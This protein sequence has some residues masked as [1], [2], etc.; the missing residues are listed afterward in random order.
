M[1]PAPRSLRVLF[2]VAG[3]F[4]FAASRAGAADEKI[5]F[6]LI[7]QHALVRQRVGLT[8][9]EV[10]YSRP[11]KNKRDIF[12]G[13]VPWEQVWRTGANAPTKIKFS[14]AVQLGGQEVAAGEYALYT[15]PTP[16]E[17]TIILSKNLEQGY[18]PE[19][20]AARFIA[21]P[22][23]LSDHLESFTIGFDDLRAG[24]ATMFLAWDKTVVPIKL[25]TNSVEKL[26]Q[27]LAAVIKSGAEQDA[28]FY[29]NAA[30]FYLEQNLD[31]TQAAKWI[32][33]GIAK[34]PDAYNM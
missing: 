27:Q 9:V 7:S 4:A 23:K 33:Q 17:W 31:L 18:K 15:V 3:C 21:T 12:G 20:D 14:E 11:N 32:D 24:S 30:G 26:K 1:I 5:E 34:S 2:L 25:Q 8:D 10:D 19:A 13:L 29:N 6:P 22:M 16:N 28:N